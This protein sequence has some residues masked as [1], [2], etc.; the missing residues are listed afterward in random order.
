M[1]ILIPDIINSFSF[2][3]LEESF[4]KNIL[5]LKLINFIFTPLKNFDDKII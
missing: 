1:V 4:S 5:Q 3:D 2:T